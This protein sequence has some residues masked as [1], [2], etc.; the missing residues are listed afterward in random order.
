[1]KFLERRA[2]ALEPRL[3]VFEIMNNDFGDNHRDGLYAL[4]GDKLVELPLHPPGWMRYV[5]SVA[6]SI[7]GLASSYTYGAVRQVPW[8]SQRNLYALGPAGDE[9][10]YKL[11]ERIAEICAGEHW[12][13]ALVTVELPPERQRRIAAIAAARHFRLVATPSST[14]RPDLYFKVD[15]HWNTHGHRA[16]ASMVWP[17]IEATL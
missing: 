3:I 15:G 16:V 10:T 6:E 17:A 8:S 11:V 5:Q 13:L 14:E 1:M 2:K 7:P 4:Q 9:L 12:P